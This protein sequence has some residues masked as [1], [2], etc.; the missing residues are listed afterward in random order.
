[1]YILLKFLLLILCN[2]SGSFFSLVGKQSKD[3]LVSLINYVCE[4]KVILTGLT[5]G[6]IIPFGLSKIEF[7]NNTLLYIKGEEKRNSQS[8]FLWYQKLRPYIYCVATLACFF[9]LFSE[10]NFKKDVEI[11]FELPL[12]LLKIIYIG[13]VSISAKQFIGTTIDGAIILMKEDN[14]RRFLGG[15]MMRIENRYYFTELIE[16]FA[17]KFNNIACA[18]SLFCMILKIHTIV[19]LIKIYQKKIISFLAILRLEK[20]IYYS[21]PKINH[22][23]ENNVFLKEEENYRFKNLIIEKDDSKKF[24]NYDQLSEDTKNQLQ[25][26]NIITRTAKMEYANLM[27]NRIRFFLLYALSIKEQK[28]K[29][30]KYIKFSFNCY[31]KMMRNHALCVGDNRLLAGHGHSNC[32]HGHFNKI[33]TSIDHHVDSPLDEFTNYIEF[34]DPFYDELTEEINFDNITIKKNVE[35][36]LISE[37]EESIKIEPIKL[38]SMFEKIFLTLKNV[39]NFAYE[40]F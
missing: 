7:V 29:Q 3:T 8:Y 36:L 17:Y 25:S 30:Q 4:N 16:D 12:D 27:D 24:I 5:A 15:R 18:I 38:S 34:N 21:K 33:L 13:G 32:N 11:D 37:N 20:M 26:S 28:E 39:E 1:M 10:E 23:Y 9:P 14:E 2:T 19:E 22:N 35:N 6:T 31:Y 40:N